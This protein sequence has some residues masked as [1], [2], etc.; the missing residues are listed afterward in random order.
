MA[1]SGNDPLKSYTQ[2]ELLDLIERQSFELDDLRAKSDQF[3]HLYVDIIQSTSWK[4]AWPIRAAFKVLT[5]VKKAVTGA[6]TQEVNKSVDLTR[7]GKAVQ[8]R[9]SFD[10]ALASLRYFKATTC[11]PRLNLLVSVH[12]SPQ[13]LERLL[14]S[15]ASVA[16]DLTMPLRIL[17]LDP[18]LTARDCQKIIQACSRQA[19]DDQVD[20]PV[21]SPTIAD[22]AAV[23]F[24]FHHIDQQAGAKG[25]FRID[26]GAGDYL[27]TQ[28]DRA[29]QAAA[30]FIWPDQ[31]IQ[32]AQNSSEIPPAVVRK[33]RQAKDE[34]ARLEGKGQ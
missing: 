8:D 7:S 26:F 24:T 33:I 13:E 2:E 20:G 17:S 12:Q 10:T 30:D 29:T 16:L 4:L 25:V 6:K 18:Q 9:G 1:T 21:A 32:L 14:H 19:L 15:I 31:T 11:Q 5:K 3:E 27:F 34:I 22:E 23:D 28:T